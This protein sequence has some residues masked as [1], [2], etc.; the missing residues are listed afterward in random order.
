MYWLWYWR[1]EELLAEAN[2]FGYQMLF[3]ATMAVLAVLFF[4]AAWNEDET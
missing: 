2:K 3:I 4:S 1:A